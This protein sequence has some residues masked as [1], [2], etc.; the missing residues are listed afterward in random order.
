MFC[1]FHDLASQSELKM[2]KG[3]LVTVI[4]TRYPTHYSS[5]ATSVPSMK[6]PS[7]KEFEIWTMFGDSL[8]HMMITMTSSFIRFLWNSN[9]NPPRAYL[10]DIP[11]FIFIGHKRHE[12]HN[13][14][15]NREMI[16]KIEIASLWLWSLTKVF[17]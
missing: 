13:G 4:T 14:E 10:S 17:Q 9:T 5:A 7:S 16:R 3:Y 8:Y 15:V 1:K 2:F 12:I 11:N 6:F